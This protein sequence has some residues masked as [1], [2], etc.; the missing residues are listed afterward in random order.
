[1]KDIGT[2]PT[3]GKRYTVPAIKDPNTGIVVYGS[4]A[5]AKYL[6]KTYPDKLL[7]PRGA[8]VLVETF[9]T[10]YINSHDAV[11]QAAHDKNSRDTE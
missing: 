10:P 3:A 4:H 8:H 9:E 11:L 6:D 2:S 1:M 7:I 5:I